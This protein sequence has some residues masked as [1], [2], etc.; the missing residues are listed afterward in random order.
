MQV[1]LAYTNSIF[2]LWQKLKWEKN[3]I[4][5]CED[6]VD[7]DYGDFSKFW[8]SASNVYHLAIIQHR[9]K[10]FAGASSNCSFLPYQIMPA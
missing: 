3:S 10:E 5:I 6:S 8:I 1:G 7:I 2:L 9:K 4:C